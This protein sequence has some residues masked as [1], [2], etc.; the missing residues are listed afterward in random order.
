MVQSGNCTH[1]SAWAMLSGLPPLADA[2][3]D[4]VGPELGS[5]GR[6]PAFQALGYRCRWLQAT[7]TSFADLD[8]ML[9]LLRIDDRIDPTETAMLDRARWNL[10]GMPDDQLIDVACR[11]LEGAASQGELLITFTISN[12]QP[13]DLPDGFSRDHSG[14]MAFADQAVGRLIAWR[15]AQPEDRRPVIWIQAD[16]GQGT[17]LA[18]HPRG[19]ACAEA[20]RVPGLLLLPD[21]AAAGQAWDGPV[22][23][24]D[25]LDLLYLL[26]AQPDA[27]TNPWV[28][29]HRVVAPAVA[30]GSRLVVAQGGWLGETVPAG[31]T[32][33]GLWGAEPGVAEP[34]RTTLQAAWDDLERQR[35]VLWP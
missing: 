22:C 21:G 16:H 17:G 20:F 24:Q 27:A 32:A 9:R 19:W 26:V 10:W 34:L 8:R 14:G 4:L 30:A 12:H 28:T 29:S 31:I 2:S 5:V 15:D 7:N 25:V 33:S 13:F 35:S 18:G 6:V 23:H 11:R 3:A 1:Q